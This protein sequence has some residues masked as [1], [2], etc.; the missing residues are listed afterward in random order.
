MTFKHTKIVATIGPA[1][2]SYDMLKQ[3]S[4]AGVNVFRLNFSHG[5]YEED[6][7]V[8]DNIKKLNA[9]T[10][11][12]HA[13]LADT[14][15]PEI[16]TGKLDEALSVHEGDEITLTIDDVTYEDTKKLHINY[17]GFI[18]DVEVG[19]VIL[20]D[21]GVIHFEVLSKSGNDVQCTILDDGELTGKRHVNLPGK[22]ISLPSITEKDWKDIQFATEIG[23]DFIALSFIR[24]AKDVLAIREFLE[25]KGHSHIQLISKIETLKAVH[26]IDD[27]FEVSDGIMVARGDLGAEIPFD[28]VP[29]R[30]LEISQKGAEYKKPVIVA[31]HMLESMIE[32]PVPTR[33]ETSDIFTAVWQQNDAVMLSGETSI[34][35]HPI[36]AVKAMAKIAQT[37]EAYT[38]GQR[39]V[40]IE[41]PKDSF[42][43]NAADS[44]DDIEET[45]FIMVITRSG[46]TAQRLSSIR[47][48]GT[49]YAF[50]ED[51]RV[52]RRLS[53]NWGTYA[54][55]I[56]LES[57]PEQTIQNAMKKLLDVEP[58]RKGQKFALLSNIL[59]DG[60]MTESLQIRTLE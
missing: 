8:A 14:K 20:I 41:N 56:T 55:K 57:A 32:D 52:C 50:S 37:T 49:I 9:D 47:P 53:L 25:E 6:G 40:T 19:E 43:K 58:E 26:N 46:D 22:D 28:E 29:L 31:T 44:M 23:A 33:A 59:I 45:Q 1:T 54:H 12:H 13:I 2:E 18:N 34:G 10:G 24:E 39:F 51:E 27:L 17:P 5:S 60:E 15:G 42:C 36:K 11:R 38:Y 3:L 30:Q 21:N 35:D 16:R 7:A 48:N 4:D